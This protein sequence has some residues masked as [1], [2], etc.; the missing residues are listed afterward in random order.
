[1]TQKEKQ[2]L[3]SARECIIGKDCSN[4]ECKNTA[5]NLDCVEFLIDKIDAVLEKDASPIDQCKRDLENLRTDLCGDVDALGYEGY[6]T[7]LTVKKFADAL[8]LMIFLFVV[9]T[10]LLNMLIYRTPSISIIM[11][12]ILYL[13]YNALS[14][15]IAKYMS[16]ELLEHKKEYTRHYVI[17]AIDKAIDDHYGDTLTPEN[18]EL[19]EKELDKYFQ[20]YFILKST[21]AANKY[22]IAK[23]SR[24][25]QE[26]Q[27]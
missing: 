6:T 4:C 13:I 16:N 1:M 22:E 23:A 25:Q 15:N 9:G 7:I 5:D 27:E 11:C 21:Y 10:H 12:I 14:Y 8:A 20:D 17:G 3:M 26:N 2:L 18:R 24:K 19:I